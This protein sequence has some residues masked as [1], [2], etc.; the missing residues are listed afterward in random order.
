VDEDDYPHANVTTYN[1]NARILVGIFTTNLKPIERKRRN[2]IRKAYLSAYKKSKTPNRICSLQDLLKKKMEPEDCQFA[3]TFVV[4]AN[5]SAPTEQ[6]DTDDLDSVAIPRHKIE[7]PEPDVLYLNIQE[8]MNDGKSDTWFRYASLIVEHELYFDYMAKMDT[9]T[10][11]F[12]HPMFGKMENWPKYPN[13]RRIYG[14]EYNVK[15]DGDN[16][17]DLLV[18]ASYF[19]G[20]FYWMSPDIAR[21]IT[22]S[23]KCNRTALRTSAEDM[24]IGNYINTFPHTIHRFQMSR[25]TYDHPFKE[26]SH[27][28]KRWGRY[29]RKFKKFHKF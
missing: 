13:N 22:H 4:G 29:Q 6:V 5:S 24:T 19:N 10:V 28:Q 1:G 18:G 9:D 14:G 12:P 3:Y 23:E 7:K 16:R 15:R 11:F 17:K 21:F 2:M 26:I 20:P 8:N 27:F 25:K